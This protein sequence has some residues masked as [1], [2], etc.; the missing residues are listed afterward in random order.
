MI[1]IRS[2]KLWILHPS[3]TSRSSLLTSRMTHFQPSSP[4]S[5]PLGTSATGERSAHRL[6]TCMGISLLDSPSFPPLEVLGKLSTGK[7]TVSQVYRFAYVLRTWTASSLL[8]LPSTTAPIIGALSFMGTPRSWLISRRRTMLCILL[9]TVSSLS[10]GLT[11]ACPWRRRKRR[12][13]GWWG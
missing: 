7:R 8:S 11:H 3:S 5:V 6:C 9:R 2:T 12:R 13:Q 4:W 1:K 10:G